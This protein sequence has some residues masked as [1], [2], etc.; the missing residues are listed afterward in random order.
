VFLTAVALIV[1][2]IVAGPFANRWLQRR[3]SSA[4]TDDP[5]TTDDP[6]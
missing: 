2:L 4:S 3:S 5:P 1:V 6:R